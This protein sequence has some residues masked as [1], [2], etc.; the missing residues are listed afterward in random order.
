MAST[1]IEYRC[2]ITGPQIGSEERMN[3]D[4]NGK[5]KPLT[6]LHRTSLDCDHMCTRC[7]K[8]EAVEVKV[9]PR[10]TVSCEDVLEDTGEFFE[11]GQAYDDTPAQK[12]RCKRCGGDRFEVATGSYLTVLRCPTCKY[13]VTVQ[14]G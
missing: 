9:W 7:P 8:A 5:P 6:A 13:E 10:S 12:A 4:E 1:R 2:T 11:T 14:N 3:L